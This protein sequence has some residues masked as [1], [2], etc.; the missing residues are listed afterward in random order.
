M[1]RLVPSIIVGSVI[2][3][4]LAGMFFG[5]CARVRKYSGLI[6]PD[7]VPDSIGEV[8]AIDRGLYVAT[9][10]ANQPLERVA[11][12]GLGFCSR[13]TVTITERGIALAPKGRVPFFI[14]RTSILAVQRATWAI[15]KAVETGGLVV[16]TWRLG[17]TELDSY[18]RM[19]DGP[20]VL[21]NT[22][23]GLI[24]VLA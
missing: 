4:A 10:M 2:V 1:D 14:G 8:I 12:H 18:F 19:D 3:L 20:A 17:D 5:W 15:D 11:A 6:A 21:L 7:A 9:T 16:L 22:G 24:E 23:A 13:A